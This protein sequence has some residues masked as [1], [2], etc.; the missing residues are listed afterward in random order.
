MYGRGGFGYDPY[1]AGAFDQFKDAFSL[2]EDEH[3][4]VKLAYRFEL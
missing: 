1:A 2:R 4:L 3:L